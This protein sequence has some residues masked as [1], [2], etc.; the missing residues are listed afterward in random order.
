MVELMPVFDEDDIQLLTEL[1]H[2]FYEKTGSIMAEKILSD[3]DNEV[4][5]FVKVFPFEYQRVLKDMKLKKP[6]ILSRRPSPAITPSEPPKDIEDLFAD[7]SKLDK[8]KGFMKY[9]R[10]KG[11]YRPA[12]ER[13]NQWGEVY[14]FKAIRENVRVQATR[15]VDYCFFN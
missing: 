11:Y 13:L 7:Q 1:I 12:A 2:E 14:D 3:W 15:Y 10:I 6:L 5:K 4:R 9:K 8:V